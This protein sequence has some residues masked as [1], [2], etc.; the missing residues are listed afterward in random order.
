MPFGELDIVPS[1]RSGNIVEEYL[2]IVS[3][4]GNENTE[5]VL[6]D[7]VA[8]VKGVGETSSTSSSWNIHGHVVH[9]KGTVQPRAIAS[10]GG[11]DTD[12]IV[13]HGSDLAGDRIDQ[14]SMGTRTKRGEVTDQLEQTGTGDGSSQV[15]C[16]NAEDDLTA[17]TKQEDSSPPKMAIRQAAFE[18]WERTMIDSKPGWE[19]VGENAPLASVVGMKGGRPHSAAQILHRKRPSSATRS[20]EFTALEVQ[21]SQQRGSVAGEVGEAAVELEIQQRDE[22]QPQQEQ[23]VVAAAAF[24]SAATLS[25][26][27]DVGLQLEE[28]PKKAPRGTH[29]PQSG[30]AM[31]TFRRGLMRKIDAASATLDN[32]RDQDA[33][34][35]QEPGLVSGLTGVRIQRQGE[36]QNIHEE[37]KM[38][39]LGAVEGAAKPSSN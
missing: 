12:R 13:D 4:K 2:Q 29:R 37:E 31:S 39:G 27:P 34:R 15:Q 24:P 22:N 36:Q 11:K 23:L 35:L 19:K 30:T 7:D 3:G 9:N 26:L 20:G 38:K 28:T 5:Y 16:F 6:L 21:R 10:N 8:N 25:V 32:M 18:M 1:G 14:I 17:C 33:A